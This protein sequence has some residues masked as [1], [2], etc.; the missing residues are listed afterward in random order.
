ML[1]AIQMLPALFW[2]AVLG[3]QALTTWLS[4]RTMKRQL[5]AQRAGQER[6]RRAAA[7]LAGRRTAAALTAA[8]ME[9]Q[10]AKEALQAATSAR[11]RA[12]FDALG[13]IAAQLAMI[14]IAQNLGLSPS[15]VPAPLQPPQE[16]GQGLGAEAG[17]PRPVS[18]TAAMMQ[19]MPPA[20]A[21]EPL[22][23]LEQQGLID[24]DQLPV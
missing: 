20:V 18:P 8:G 14:S 17:V 16:Q 1:A 7:M 21:S 11:Q 2:L 23:V 6:A 12:G 10:R 19:R 3:G 9:K 24:L 5:K 22:L 4:S 13:D 15:G